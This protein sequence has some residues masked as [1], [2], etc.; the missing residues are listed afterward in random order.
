MAKLPNR[1]TPSGPLAPLLNWLNQLREYVAS[2]APMPAP[3]SLVSRT[4]RGT[5]ITPAPQ[6]GGGGLTLEEYD[7]EESFPFRSVVLVEEDNI[8]VTEGADDPDNPGE[9]VY[10]VPGIYYRKNEAIPEGEARLPI[11][12]ANDYWQVISILPSLSHAC[13]D[14]EDVEVWSDTR[15]TEPDDEEE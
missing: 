2:I 8:A 6:R 15:R 3:N 5:F 9:T 10:S 13:L 11:P 7:M 14:G 12:S 1:L 4:T